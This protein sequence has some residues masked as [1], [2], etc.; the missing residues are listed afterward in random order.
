MQNEVTNFY[1]TKVL[2][3]VHETHGVCPVFV[4]TYAV[5][6][7][8][9][10]LANDQLTRVLAPPTQHKLSNI[11]HSTISTVVVSYS[12]CPYAL[13]LERSVALRAIFV[14]LRFTWEMLSPPNRAEFR[15]NPLEC[16]KEDNR[17]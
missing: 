7:S 6:S 5:F 16:P 9:P 1:S 12:M 3:C 11:L 4:S 15:A 13:R 17:K 2:S 8:M 14:G 10:L